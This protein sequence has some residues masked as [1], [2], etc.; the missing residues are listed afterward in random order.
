MT[1][2]STIKRL[3]SEYNLGNDRLAVV[4][5][6]FRDD[7]DR[8]M[9]ALGIEPA[10]QGTYLCN[11]CNSG[12]GRNGTGMFPHLTGSGLLRFHCFACE[13]SFRPVEGTMSIHPR[14]SFSD[15][16]DYLMQL[17]APGFATFQAQRQP[18]PRTALSARVAKPAPSL[19]LDDR[20]FT[21]YQ[22]S[23]FY[24]EACPDWQQKMA[25]ALGLP[26][27]ALSRPDI[28]K[29]FVDGDNDGLNPDAGDLVTYNLLQGK[30]QSLK[31][32]HVPGLGTRGLVAMLDYAANVFRFS[33]NPGDDRTFRMAG[34]SGELCFGHDSI[35]D[36]TSTVIITEGQSDA[37]AVCAAASAC[38]RADVTAIARDS[39]S[40]VLKSPDLDALAGKAVVYCEDD[41]PAGRS[42]T[43]ENIACLN[44]H[45]CKVASWCAAVH[46]C[47][48]ARDVFRSL[49]AHALLDSILN[50][51]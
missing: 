42:K 17:Y 24:R 50:I 37:L 22:A 36:A 43:Q 11:K 45:G 13:N 4:E 20:L 16:L 40:H 33:C 48:D 7:P 18:R 29:A 27:S 19:E 5:S 12:R 32:R 9:S 39:A 15:A 46:G 49:G 38:C 21:T 6:R 44:A 26:F 10:S 8:L 30:P 2:S 34:A 1:K 51:K 25:D 28:G 41:D 3:I 23:V 35:T 14:M 31:V 47:K